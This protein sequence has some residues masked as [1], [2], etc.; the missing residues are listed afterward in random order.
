[1]GSKG[2]RRGAFY[3]IYSVD[4][5]N[6]NLRQ[7]LASSLDPKNM[8]NFLQ[9]GCETHKKLGKFLFPIGVI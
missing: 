1:M 6:P 5:I 2:Y 7:F 3:F 9:I 4:P 8:L